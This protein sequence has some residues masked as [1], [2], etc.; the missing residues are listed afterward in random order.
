MFVLVTWLINCVGFVST[1]HIVLY[2]IFDM[3]LTQRGNMNCHPY[4]FSFLFVLISGICKYFK[5]P[6]VVWNCDGFKYSMVSPSVIRS[7]HH[8]PNQHL[9]QVETSCIMAKLT[10]GWN[11]RIYFVECLHASIHKR[12]CLRSY[13]R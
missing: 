4:Q 10:R 13:L 8:Q 7:L 6:L 9:H 5:S 2:L 11:G 12:N 3:T 1:T